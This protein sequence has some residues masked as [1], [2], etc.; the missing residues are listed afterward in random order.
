MSNFENLEKSWLNGNLFYNW[1][2]PHGSLKGKTST[3]VAELRKTPLTE[4]VY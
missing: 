2:R 4:E 3:I 1:Q